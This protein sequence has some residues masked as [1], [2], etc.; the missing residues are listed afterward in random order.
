MIRFCVALC[1]EIFLAFI[2]PNSVVSH[3]F[4]SLL[5]YRISFIVFLA[6]Y[7]LTRKKFHDITTL[8]TN[9]IFIDF[10]NL[11]HLLFIDF[12]LFFFTKELLHFV[13]CNDSLTPRTFNL[14]IFRICF[15]RMFLQAM[16]MNL[17]ET[18]TSLQHGHVIIMHI[19]FCDLFIAEM[20]HSV[21]SFLLH[22]FHISCSSSSF[23]WVHKVFF[24]H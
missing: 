6:F 2:T 12:F 17:M 14:F 3:M 20:A 7:Y 18:I 11:H 1:A 23:S 22:S 16:N 4:S 10:N 15:N 21:L 24:V 8:T 5:G 13:F 19:F 9:K